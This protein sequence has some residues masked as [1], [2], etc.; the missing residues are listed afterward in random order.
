MPKFDSGGVKQSSNP[1]LPMN[2]E[3]KLVFAENFAAKG[4]AAAQEVERLFKELLSLPPKPTTGAGM[5]EVPATFNTSFGRVLVRRYLRGGFI[6]KFNSSWHLWLAN[7]GGKGQV[8][9][10]RSVEELRVL[11]LLQVAGFNV[12]TAYAAAV[13]RGFAGLAYRAAICMEEITDAVSL[14]KLVEDN[15]KPNVLVAKPGCGGALSTADIS[16]FAEQAGREAGAI[17]R[18][19]IL[20]RDLHPGNVLVNGERVIVI[21]FDRAERIGPEQVGSSITFLCRRWQRACSKRGYPEEVA[22]AFVRGL[23]NSEIQEKC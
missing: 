18:H 1:G 23:T 21:D 2:R 17:C 10:T 4:P 15:S 3:L 11:E 8:E 5:R 9:S 14:A 12:P 13:E 19:G 7:F 20:H 16:G 6:S 22:R